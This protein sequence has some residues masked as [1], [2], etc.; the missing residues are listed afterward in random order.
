MSSEPLAFGVRSYVQGRSQSTRTAE[1]EIQGYQGGTLSTEP[2]IS[3]GNCV[4]TLSGAPPHPGEVFTHYDV[5]GKKLV[6]GP[7]GTS[8]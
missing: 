2:V 5:Q 1:S 3:I 4:I 7:L 8:T 6:A